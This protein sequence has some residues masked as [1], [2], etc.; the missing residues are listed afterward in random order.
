[1]GSGRLEPIDAL[2]RARGLRMWTR[3]GTRP[4]FFQP[5]NGQV[6]PSRRCSLSAQVAWRHSADRG[7]RRGL[8]G[9]GGLGS[10]RGQPGAGLGRRSCGE[11]FRFCILLLWA[12]QTGSA[13]GC[14]RDT[15]WGFTPI[16]VTGA[17][18]GTTPPAALR[19]LGGVFNPVGADVSVAVS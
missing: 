19:S 2:G 8:P 13:S 12:N 5:S 18:G 10:A 11:H 14:W 16:P 4:D 6:A 3:Q 9:A 15:T 7:D 17:G 1:M